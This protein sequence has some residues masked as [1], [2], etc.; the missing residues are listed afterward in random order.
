[1]IDT[2]QITETRRQLAAV[3]HV[4]VARDKIREVMGPG[5]AEVMAAV[6]AQGVGPVGPWFTHHFRITPETFDFEIGV[7]TSAPV[8]A[9]GRVKPGELPAGRVARTVYHGSYEGLGEA[10]GE[11]FSWIETAGHKQASD[12]W[13]VYLAGPESSADPADYRTELNRPLVE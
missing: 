13:E 4:V 9:T 11:L 6:K 5:I 2:P 7:P 1:M 12:H 10:V 8:A 3:I